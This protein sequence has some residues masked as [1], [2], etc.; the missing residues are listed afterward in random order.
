MAGGGVEEEEVAS[1]VVD[2]LHEMVAQPRNRTPVH[3]A[4]VGVAFGEVVAEGD[5]APV[6]QCDV[7]PRA[8]RP[9]GRRASPW[10]GG[11]AGGLEG[12]SGDESDSGAHGLRG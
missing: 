9:Y 12:E 2:A 7:R 5:H 1:L 8:V 3:V 6:R 11:G 4:D 10:R